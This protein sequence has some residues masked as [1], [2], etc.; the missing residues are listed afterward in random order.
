MNWDLE[1]RAEDSVATYLK[2]QCGNMRVYAAWTM[3]EPQFPCAVVHCSESGPISETANWHEAR[4]LK[5]AVAVIT[6][7][8]PLI[9]D[10]VEILS[11]RERNAIARSDVLATLGVDGL[12]ALLNAAGIAGIYFAMAQVGTC[13][14]TVDEATRRLITTI[15]VDAIA[16]P[17][18]V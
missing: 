18:E 12:G 16:S 2:A 17:Q 5:I 7:A 3:S 8:A 6:E 11:A 14:R 4:E 15:T 13:T 1:E 9:Q 10:G